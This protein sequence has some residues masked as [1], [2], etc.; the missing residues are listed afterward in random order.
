MSSESQSQYRVVVLSTHFN[1]AQ[2]DQHFES[3]SKQKDCTYLHYVI[4]NKAF[5]EGQAELHKI[6]QQKKNQARYFLKLDG[7]MVIVEET[8]LKKVCDFLDRSPTSVSRLTLPVHDYFTGMQLLGVHV[9][10]ADRTPQSVKITPPRGDAWLDIIP[11]ITVP[12]L[13]T[14][15]VL[16]AHNPSVLQA[17][18]FGFNR[19]IK[20]KHFG[21][22]HKHWRTLYYLERAYRHRPSEY[23]IGT[24]LV[25][26][27]VALGF[28]RNFKVELDNY[29]ES[30]IIASGLEE[31]LRYEEQRGHSFIRKQLGKPLIWGWLKSFDSMGLATTRHQLK[32]GRSKLLDLV[33]PGF[34]L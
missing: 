32:I 15:Q 22:N 4:K 23:R 8:F 34:E 1:E 20:A 31:F 12:K 14:E 10:R 2:L 21:A 6:A 18:R 11:G 3:L 5:I 25:G 17:F 26:A 24:A 19:A 16:H 30:I 29:D 13:K 27:S 7:D 9:W 33:R 28:L